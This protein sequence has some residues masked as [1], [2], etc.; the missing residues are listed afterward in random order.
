[1]TSLPRPRPLPL[2]A[3]VVLVAV[4]ALAGCGKGKETAEKPKGFSE[5]E[6][7]PGL[8]NAQSIPGKA[9]AKAET[10]VCQNN[11]QQCRQSIR[12]D[13]DQG[14]AAPQSLDKGATASVSKCPITGKPYS[15]DR[16]TG[17]VWCTTAGHEKY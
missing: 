6:Y 7:H 1:M 11:L 2:L 15:Y 12:M 4:M 8:E 13:M 10:T 3:L 17:K 16:Q 5:Q 9:L 14:A